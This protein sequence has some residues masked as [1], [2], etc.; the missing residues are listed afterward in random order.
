MVRTAAFALRFCKPILSDQRVN[1]KIICSPSFGARG[2]GFKSV[3]EL[4]ASP[5][6]RVIGWIL[7]TAG[8]LCCSNDFAILHTI[9]TLFMGHAMTTSHLVEQVCGTLVEH[10]AF[11]GF[12]FTVHQAA[13]TF[14]SGTPAA[15]LCKTAR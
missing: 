8:F 2:R 11:L 13:H 15:H 12:H 1:G 14:V 10:G 9:A 3:G 5:G 7:F 4:W 6:V